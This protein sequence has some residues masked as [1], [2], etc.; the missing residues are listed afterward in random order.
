MKILTS[1]A[2]YLHPIVRPGVG[3]LAV[4]NG[5]YAIGV[6]V[7]RPYE[8]IQ[9][10]GETNTPMTYSA[11]SEY[12]HTRIETPIMITGKSLIKT[13]MGSLAGGPPNSLYS[14]TFRL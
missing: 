6:V 8:T 11:T 10:T 9:I 7:T 13:M 2:T 5:A 14:L 1:S 4:G 3:A 12:L